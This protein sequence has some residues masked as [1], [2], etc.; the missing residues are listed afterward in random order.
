MDDKSIVSRCLSGDGEA[1]EM[2]VNKY[3]SQLL[4]FTWSIMGDEE[5]AKVW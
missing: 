2:I 4:H 3:Q 1:F 5:E